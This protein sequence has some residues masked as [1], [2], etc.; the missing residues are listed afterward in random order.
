MIK[1][2]LKD[3]AGVWMERMKMLIMSMIV[4]GV[5]IAMD[6]LMDVVN[7]IA[8]AIVTVNVMIVL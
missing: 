5:Q 6:V 2:Y 8:I 4:V 1:V 3:C 7:V